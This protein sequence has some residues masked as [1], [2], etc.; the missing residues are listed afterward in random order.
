MAN[1]DIP[2]FTMKQN[3]PMAAV[4][5]SQNRKAQLQQEMQLQQEKMFQQSMQAIAQTATSLYAQKQKVASQLALGRQLGFPDD[6]SKMM[7]TDDMIKVATIK[8]SQ[9]DPAQSAAMAQMY[10]STPQGQQMLGTN[11]VA[12]S[13]FGPVAM[14]QTAMGGVDMAPVPNSTGVTTDTLKNAL[15]GMKPVD[16]IK[17]LLNKNN[18]QVEDKIAITDTD[19]NIV[20]YQKVSHDKGGRTILSRPNTP[21]TA[22]AMDPGKAEFKVVDTFNAN[23]Q[24]RKQQQSIDGAFAV[25]ALATSDNPIAAAAIPTYMARA[26]GEVGNL[27][28]ADKAPF[29]GSQAIKNRLEAAL[30]QQAT[31]QLTEANRTFLMQLSDTMEKSAE[32]NLDRRA[33]EFANQYSRSSKIS[34]HDLYTSLRPGRQSGAT[35][36]APKV[37]QLNP[38][39][40]HMSTADLLKLKEQMKKSR[41]Q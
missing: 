39:L 10:G 38:D 37:P 35:P 27:S 31:G 30:K 8:K 14:N 22:L 17:N 21:R 34:P 16:M 9:D 19:G 25:R 26:S 32:E 40:A 1:Q 6:Q 23:P 28:E 2:D 5:D 13:P 41:G 7:S 4:L 20:D 18:G 12:T 11:Q 15:R 33:M 36:T 29:G 24:V 3:F